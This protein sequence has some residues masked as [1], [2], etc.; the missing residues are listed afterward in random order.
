MTTIE[1]IE[2]D[3]AKHVKGGNI[4]NVMSSLENYFIQHKKDIIKQDGKAHWEDMLAKSKDENFVHDWF[5]Y[6]W[7]MARLGK[8]ERGI[9]VLNVLDIFFDFYKIME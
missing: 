4:Q 8:D 1:Y 6:R 2:F 7:H 3:P 5:Q 9:E